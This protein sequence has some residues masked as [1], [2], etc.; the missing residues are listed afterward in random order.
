MSGAHVEICVAEICVAEICVAEICVAEIC[1][2]EICVAETCV[3]EQ[4]S[5]CTALNNAKEM[6]SKQ[7]SRK[8]M[9]Q[10]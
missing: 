6:R 10:Q 9:G 2:A 7:R 8:E 3:A 1:V 4:N 5:L